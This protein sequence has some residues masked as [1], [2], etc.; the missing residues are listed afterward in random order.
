MSPG[1]TPVSDP[2]ALKA[3]H[4]A[5]A[6]R[7]AV[8]GS[9]DAA[10]RALYQ[11]FAGLIG[12]GTCVALAWDRWGPLKPGA[13]RRTAHGPPV[14]LYLAMVVT[15]VLLSLSIRSFLRVRRLMREEH[16]LFDRYRALRSTL[17]LDT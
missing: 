8:R 13:T 7:L 10:R 6:E 1:Q 9:V 15:V 2:V 4:D 16:A 12:T 5:L 17:G 11:I 3:E 14:F